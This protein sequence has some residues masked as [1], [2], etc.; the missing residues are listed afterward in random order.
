MALFLVHRSLFTLLL[1]RTSIIRQSLSP[2]RIYLCSLY[3]CALTF[4][5]CTGLVHAA[6][7]AKPVILVLGDSLSAG[8]GIDQSAGW[9]A[10]LEKKIQHEGYS[11]TIINASISG[12]TTGGGLAR[13][14]ALLAQ[15][16]PDI[17][18]IELGANDGLRGFPTKVISNNLGAMV[19]LGKKQ[20]T[21]VLLI[22]VQL[23]LNYGPRYTDAFEKTFLTVSRTHKVALAPSL[24]GKVPLDKNLMQ[25]DGL[26]PNAAA[27]PQL[28]QHVWPFLHTLLKATNTP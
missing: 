9:V 22:G 20:R 25:N 17:L 4:S 1:Y 19:S 26:H 6:A 16:Q 10:L 3:L 8:Y 7:T 5:A 21:Q 2:R 18:L 24:L 15:H 28:L 12:E 23:P 14:P 27:Q 11:A 13:L